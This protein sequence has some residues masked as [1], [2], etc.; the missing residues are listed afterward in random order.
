MFKYNIWYIKVAIPSKVLHIPHT[1]ECYFLIDNIYW[2]LVL[3][4]IHGRSGAIV[5]VSV[6]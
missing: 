1:I 5:A 3:L 6:W 4:A 2:L